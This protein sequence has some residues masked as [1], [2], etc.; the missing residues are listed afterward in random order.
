MRWGVGT[1]AWQAP[2]VGSVPSPPNSCPYAFRVSRENVE[3]VEVIHRRWNAGESTRKLIDEDLEYVNPPDAVETGTLRGRGALRR[4][5]EVYPDYRVEI[6]QIVDAGDEVAICAVVR[7]T[8]PSG[9]SIEG[10]QGFVW[11]VQEGRAVRFQWFREPAEALAAV[12]HE[13]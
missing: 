8:S 6:E 12:G 13:P 10:R 7:G 1:A 4:V 11:T 9:L 2:A 5:L 3:L